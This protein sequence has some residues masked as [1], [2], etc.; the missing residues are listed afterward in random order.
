M[1]HLPERLRLS[2]VREGT[3]FSL[4][5]YSVNTL[6]L[7]DAVTIALHLRHRAGLSTVDTLLTIRFV[8]L[9]WRQCFVC[10]GVELSQE[11]NT[12]ISFKLSRSLNDP[13]NLRDIFLR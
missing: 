11:K 6:L 2:T 7:Q 3:Y 10:F 12:E 4:S 13:T 5:R 1:E 9:Y 8:F